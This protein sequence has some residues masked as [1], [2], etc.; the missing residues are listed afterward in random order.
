MSYSR[1]GQAFAHFRISHPELTKDEVRTI[2]R[3]AGD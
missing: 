3:L 2:W 1:Q